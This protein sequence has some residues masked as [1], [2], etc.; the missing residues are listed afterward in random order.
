MSDI[1]PY[2]SPESTVNETP[3]YADLSLHPPRAV[4]FGQGMHWIS[5]GFSLFARAPWMAM[6]MVIIMLGISFVAYFVPLGSLAMTIIWPIFFGGMMLGANALH[7]G[8]PLELRHLFIAFDSHGGKL[9][10]IGGLYF[11]SV[12]VAMLFALIVGLIVFFALGGS[13]FLMAVE[14]QDGPPELLIISGLIALLS[15]LLVWI[16][17][18]LAFWFSP[19]LVVRHDLGVMDAL[20][21]SFYG[22][23]YN[24]L[25]FFLYSLVLLVLFVLGSLPLFLGL[26]VI[27][28]VFYGS[29]YMSYRD[30][31]LD[32]D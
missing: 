3:A 13:D 25:P 26:L 30:I 23:L 2:Q 18:S 29:V 6:L 20:S 21:A 8:E 1:N 7:H 14:T 32:A 22:C 31:Y 19:I 15:A 5:G 12:L 16:P 17:L 24:I 9:A 10:G 4:P 28:P 11:A 27:W